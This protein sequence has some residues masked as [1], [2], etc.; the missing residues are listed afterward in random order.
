MQHLPQRRTSTVF[1]DWNTAARNIEPNYA[2][3]RNSQ[4]SLNQYSDP[5]LSRLIVYRAAVQARTF[6]DYDNVELTSDQAY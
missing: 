6:N 4:T 5:E 2:N 1:I 3:L